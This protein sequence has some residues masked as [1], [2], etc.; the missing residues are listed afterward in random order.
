MRLSYA[1]RNPRQSFW[2]QEYVLLTN[3]TWAV[4]THHNAKIFRRRFRVPHSF[5][6]EIVR[7]TL[8][9]N[10]FP[11]G[12]RARRQDM[13]PLEL[14]ILGVL[15]VLGRG[16]SFDQ[17]AECTHSSEDIHRVFFHR[18][19]K[20]YATEILPSVLK[21]PT[22]EQELLECMTEYTA[23]GLP[24]CFGSVD[25]TH[26]PLDRCPASL[27]QLH[28]GKEG[29]PTRVYNMAVNHRRQIMSITFGFEGRHL[30]FQAPCEP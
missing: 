21:C 16:V 30:F 25:A 26:V 9:R 28:T 23:M 24:G 11:T 17:I 29:F 27:R 22:T 3:P 13:V 2:Y 12:K 20:L 8:E 14:K 10:W 7:I 1:K 6:M 18:F 15:S 19:V 5:F 4:P